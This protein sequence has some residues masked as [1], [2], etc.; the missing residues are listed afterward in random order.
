M[1]CLELNDKTQ[2]ISDL[3][4]ENPEYCFVGSLRFSNMRLYSVS[5]K[6]VLGSAV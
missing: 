3:S 1:R 2:L 4:L 6:L 5:E